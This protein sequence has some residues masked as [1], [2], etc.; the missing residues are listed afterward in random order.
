MKELELLIGNS[1][2]A[3]INGFRTVETLCRQYYNT[4]TTY[5]LIGETNNYHIFW[6]F[7]INEALSK[8]MYFSIIP[9]LMPKILK[10]Y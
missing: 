7:N 5:M 10:E 3:E 2:F 8:L 6:K 9:T 1:A 4:C